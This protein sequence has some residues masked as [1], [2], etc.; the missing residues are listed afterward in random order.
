M[1]GLVY[2]SMCMKKI[3]KNKKVTID[4]L[5]QMIQTQF[6]S[7][8]TRDRLFAD[9]QRLMQGDITD[10]KTSLKERTHAE[11]N[12]DLEIMSLDLRVK[13]LERKAGISR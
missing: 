4:I 13:T 3:P 7:I 10:I 1:W 2:N 8:D 11:A 5:V 6:A 12:Q 9:Q